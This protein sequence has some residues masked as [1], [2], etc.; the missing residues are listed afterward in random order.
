MVGNT[1]VP[2][3]LVFEQAVIVGPPEVHQFAVV[4]HVATVDQVAAEGTDNA[5]GAG[6]ARGLDDTDIRAGQDK[7]V[8]R[9]VAHV[10][11]E[12][13][14]DYQVVQQGTEDSRVHEDD[15]AFFQGLV[16]HVEVN[17]LDSIVGTGKT[18]KG[19]GNRVVVGS[20]LG[21]ETVDGVGVAGIAHPDKGFDALTNLAQQCIHDVLFERQFVFGRSNTDLPF[22]P[23]AQQGFR[24]NLAVFLDGCDFDCLLA[25]GDFVQGIE[26]AATAILEDTRKA[27]VIEI[28]RPLNASLDTDKATGAI[29]RQ[30]EGCDKQVF[31]V[32][33]I[34]GKG[35]N[36]KVSNSHSCKS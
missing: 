35:R 15:T 4:L 24:A 18:S 14:K 22:A 23:L 13:V 25:Q 1:H 29:V 11:V 2:L 31:V 36:E 28:G 5:V 8:L 33:H 21:K 7:F 19:R 20:E 16:G 26:T 34:V 12:V 9:T 32:L 6:Q 17:G 27:Q 3:D 30:S 10:V